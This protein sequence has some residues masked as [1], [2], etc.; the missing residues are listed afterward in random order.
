MIVGSRMPVILDEWRE[1]EDSYRLIERGPN[2]AQAEGPE[3]QVWSPILDTWALAPPAAL[4]RRLAARVNVNN[5]EARRIS[6]LA[7]ALMRCIQL[8]ESLVASASMETMLTATAS[9]LGVET[10]RRHLAALKGVALACGMPLE[11]WEV[12]L[13]GM[14]EDPETAEARRRLGLD[15]KPVA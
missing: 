4:A 7:A 15:V 13:E 1:G 2:G 5:V 9:A 10:A 14:K 11:R 6:F 12:E 3:G 8:G